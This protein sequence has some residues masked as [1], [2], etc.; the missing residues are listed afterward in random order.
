MPK[1]AIRT[2][3]E[4]ATHRNTNKSDSMTAADSRSVL[5]TRSRQVSGLGRLIPFLEWRAL[6][7]TLAPTLN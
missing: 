4:E 2:K 5:P 6:N 1:T 7:T 3:K